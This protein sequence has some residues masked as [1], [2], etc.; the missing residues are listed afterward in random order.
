MV[1][2]SKLRLDIFEILL[3]EN[4]RFFG[5]F[6]IANFR[7]FPNWKFLEFSKSEIFGISQIGKLKKF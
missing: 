4:F 5:V 1:D 2:V 3:I 7:N 6:Q